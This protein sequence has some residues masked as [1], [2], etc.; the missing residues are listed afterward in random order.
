[1]KPATENHSIVNDSATMTRLGWLKAKMEAAVWIDAHGELS[2]MQQAKRL[3]FVRWLV[4]TGR[5]NEGVR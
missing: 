2:T 5:I 3:A 1:M 4:R